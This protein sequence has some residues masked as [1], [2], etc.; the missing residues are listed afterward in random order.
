MLTSTVPAASGK[1]AKRGNAA[2]L[3]GYDIF[4]SF[5]LGSPPRGT[6]SYASDLARRLRER[7]FTVFFSE[8]EA[9][10]GEVLDSSLRGA[11]RRSKT[12]VVIAN[13]GTL[14]DPRWVRKEVEAFRER[15]PT[16]PIVTVSVGG[17]L[18]D[19]SIAAPTRE[20]LSV[21]DKIWLDESDEAVERGF[22][23]EALVDRLA[24]APTR[25]KSNSSWRWVVRAVVTILAAL[26]VALGVATKIA[27]DSATRAREE[28][29][30]A[31]ALRLAAEAPLMLSGA[32]R[33]GDERALLQLVAAH[34]IAPGPDIDGSLMDVVLVRHSLLKLIRNDAPVDTVAF[35]PDGRLIASGDGN[36]ILAHG[37]SPIGN[38]RLWDAATGR[39]EGAPLGAHDSLVLALAFSPDGTRIASGSADRTLRMWDVKGRRLIGAPLGHEDAVTAVAFTP[40]GTRLVS[41]SEDNTIRF[42]N[43]KTEAP[44]GTPHH[45]HEAGLGTVA[46]SRDGSLLVSGGFRPSARVWNALTGEQIRAIEGRDIRSV[47]ISPDSA[48]IIAGGR[49]PGGTRD[50]D[51][52]LQLFD[53]ASGEPVGDWLEGHKEAVNSVAWSLDG[54]RMVSASDD[55]TI[56]V[57]DPSTVKPVATLLGHFG[58]VAAVAF[59]ADSRRLVSGGQDATIRVWD[60]H[61]GESIGVP[62]QTESGKTTT[63]VAVSPDGKRIG[64]GETDGT[65]RFWEANTLRLI[66]ASPEHHRNMVTSLAFSPDS[67]RLVSASTDGTLRLWDA[68]SGAVIGEPLEGHKGPVLTVAWSPDGSRIASG[69]HALVRRQSVDHVVRIWDAQSGRLLAELEGHKGLIS[70]VA[71]NRDGRLVS[72]GADGT[73]RIWDLATNRLSREIRGAASAGAGHLATSPDGSVLLMSD[74]GDLRLWD[75]V[76]G[77]P[78]GKLLEGHDQGVASAAFSPDGSR[79][80]SGS[81]DGTLRLW[82]AATGRPVGTPFAGHQKDVTSVAYTPDGMRIVSASDDGTVRVWPAPKAW[83]ELLCEKLTRNM[84]HAEWREWISPEIEYVLQCPGLPVPPD[85]PQRSTQP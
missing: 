2:R 82:D 34:R 46:I 81:L 77:Q 25:F 32:H 37:E 22:A 16:R 84:T 5:A 69:G 20:W 49:R 24:T 33:G 30:R 6:Q 7:D 70:S 75:A 65:L 85:P 73:I 9:P 72:A 43:A 8:D 39:G 58:P 38:V 13:R 53:L 63:A 60:A 23:T 67:T 83:P 74:G 14:L 19:A 1:P 64:S 48:R 66:R 56:I 26:A 80:V 28:L 3:F 18:Q 27:N 29:R 44:I 42:W 4:I 10:P 79:I 59:S 78:I 31:M 36:A 54:S 71:F 76:S 55:G 45:G 12:L 51:D 17:A 11:L 52:Y 41:G 61:A 21:D 47:A 68:G 50:Q 57:W 35:S 15:H 40:D 62:L